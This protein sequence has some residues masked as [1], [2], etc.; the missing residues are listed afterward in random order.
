VLS[1]GDLA[2]QEKTAL[3]FMQML[4]TLETG[5]RKICNYISVSLSFVMVWRWTFCYLLHFKTV[6]M[7]KVIIQF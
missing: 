2:V 6:F 7:N 4:G 5:W 3:E 1:A